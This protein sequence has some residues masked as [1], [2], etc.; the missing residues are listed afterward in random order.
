MTF[1]HFRSTRTPF[2]IFPRVRKLH[3]RARGIISRRFELSRSRLDNRAKPLGKGALDSWRQQPR[4]HSAKRLIPRHSR[5]AALQNGIKAWRFAGG[6]ADFRRP[7][8][9]RQR[10]FAA[11]AFG[12]EDIKPRRRN[13]SSLPCRRT[14]LQLPV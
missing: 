3:R 12:I 7:P 8:N 1:S 9:S 13:S 6:T 2:H 11:A 5:V 4:G 14:L 10:L